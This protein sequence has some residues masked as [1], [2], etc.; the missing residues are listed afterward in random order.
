MQL[1]KT[2]YFITGAISFLICIS[3]QSFSQNEPKQKW[4]QAEKWK[5][6]NGDFINAHGAGILKFQKN[7]IYTVK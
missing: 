1:Q 2:I 6:T 3:V 4:V 7:I 5:D